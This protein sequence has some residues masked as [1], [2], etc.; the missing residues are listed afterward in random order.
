[1][2]CFL[3]FAHT[4]GVEQHSA[5]PL[6]SPQ[7]KVTQENISRLIISACCFVELNWISRVP[8]T[9]RMNQLLVITYCIFS[10]VVNSKRL[11]LSS[12]VEN[13]KVLSHTQWENLSISIDWIFA[14]AQHLWLGCTLQLAY[15]ILYVCGY[16][17]LALW[18]VV[19]RAQSNITM[20]VLFL[21]HPSTHQSHFCNAVDFPL[22][23]QSGKTLTREKLSFQTWFTC[24]VQH[25]RRFFSKRLM[26]RQQHADSRGKQSAANTLHQTKVCG[27]R[28][29]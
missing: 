24:H 6:S 23:G 20:L 10:S 29:N 7:H 13:N 15:C 27:W 19:L 22:R 4:G 18:T 11:L 2:A 21:D 16:E 3:S 17:F 1:M 28:C 12:S 25:G 5:Q 9:D 8:F 26:F 14:A